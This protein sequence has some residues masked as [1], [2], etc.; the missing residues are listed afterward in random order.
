M[1]SYLIFS[2]NRQSL[3]DNEQDVQ[4]RFGLFWGKVAQKFSNN[5]YVLG[6]ELLNEPWAG[7]IYSHIDQ[8]EPSQFAMIIIAFNCTGTQ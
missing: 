1:I 2:D 5:P 3:Y 7:D 4:E 8:A 6:Y